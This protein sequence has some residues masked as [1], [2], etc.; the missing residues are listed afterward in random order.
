MYLAAITW[1]ANSGESEDN[2]ESNSSMS[3]VDKL[4]KSGIVF[5]NI[6]SLKRNL[7]GMGMA[8]CF[9]FKF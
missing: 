8:G 2:P 1:K 4:F 5:D 9:K 7:N 6:R 3:S